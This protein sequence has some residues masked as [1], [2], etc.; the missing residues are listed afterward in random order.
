MDWFHLDVHTLYPDDGLVVGYMQD[1]VVCMG[2]SDDSV[3]DGS[4]Y[5]M[6]RIQNVS[7]DNSH[8]SSNRMDIRTYTT[9]NPKSGP[10]MYSY[11]YSMDIC[12]SS[13]SMQT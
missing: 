5:N 6:Y 7:T 4:N 1:D 3:D 9:T 8:S 2:Y 13:R 12:I 10:G 11:M